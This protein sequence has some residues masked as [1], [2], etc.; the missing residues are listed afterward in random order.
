MELVYEGL[1]GGRMELA[2]KGLAEGGWMELV[3]K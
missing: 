1:E 2:Y 3:Y